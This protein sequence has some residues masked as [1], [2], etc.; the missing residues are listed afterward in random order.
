MAS[1]G[2]YEARRVH[3]LSALFSV[4][5]A[6]LAS[7]SS[8]RFALKV[9]HPPASS[10]IRRFYA[11]EGWL[12][13]IERQRAAAQPGGVVVAI[14][15]SGRCPEGAFVVTAWEE[16][17]FE[18]LVDTVEAKGDHL[19]SFA[20]LL[21]R[22]LADWEQQYGGPHGRLKP[23]N[24]FLAGPG[25]LLEAKAR[26][27]DP[28]YLPGAH[29]EQLRTRDLASV[30]A[31]LV[32]SVR[33]R[34]AGGWPVEDGPEWLALGRAG[35]A[36]L[37]YCNYLL[38]THPAPGTLTIEQ[39][40][41]RLA[42]I[43]RD[44][45]P[46]RTFALG[47]GAT[48]L[49]VVGGVLGFARFGDPQVMP[50]RLRRLAEATG[51]ERAF[52]TE[53]TPDWARLCRAWATWLGDVQRNGPRWERLENFWAPDDSL[54]KA[55][56]GFQASA[57]K[58]RPQA[59][60]EAAAAETRLGVLADAPPDKVR[61]ELLRG[62]VAESV[63]EAWTQVDQL[64]QELER[65][66]RWADL[67]KLLAVLETRGFVRAAAALRPRLPEAGA[68]PGIAP[69][70]VRTL[71]LFN[72]V[73]QDDAGTLLLATQW[74]EISRL[75]EG[76]DGSGD[77]VQKAMPS[78][79][80]AR[81]ADNPSLGEFAD[82]LAAPLAELRRRRTQFLD[83]VVV[84]ER[85]L[86]ECPLQ[87]ETRAV[88]EEDL[89][90]WEQELALYSVVKAADD[91][92]VAP[93]L[94][95]IV[96][97]LGR[98]AGDL[99][100]EA[101]A[102]DAGTVT[103]GRGDFDRAYSPLT[104]QLRNLR[105]RA[106]VRR[107]LAEV[108]AE[109]RHLVA[110]LQGLERQLEAT[111]ALL[112]PGV[113]LERMAGPVGK[114]E[115]VRQRWAAWQQ[116][117]LKGL[118]VAVLEKDRARFR[119][120]R[121]REQLIREVLVGLEGAEGLGG[122]VLPALDGVGADAAAALRRLEASRREDTARAAVA[123]V[124]WRGP[125]PA[126]GWPASLP[127]VRPVLEAHARW[128]S[129]LPSFGGELDRLA[130]L[131]GEG[132]GWDE[133]VGDLIAQ[134]SRREGLGLLTGPV[135]ERLADARRL[136]GLV[137][138]EDRAELVAAGQGGGLAQK[139]TVWRRLGSLAG[140]P[141]GAEDLDRDGALVSAVREL[142]A[143]E[144]KPGARRESLLGELAR[145]T[146]VR[147]NRAARTASRGGEAAMTAVFERMDRVG[148][149]Q[150]D[151]EE[152]LAYNFLLWQLKRQ[153]P[154]EHDVG[155]LGRRRDAFA[156][157]VRALP[158]GAR[159]EI[160]QFLQQLRA[161]D[162]AED[163]KRK[164]SAS[165]G[166][167]PGWTEESADGGKTVIASWIGPEGRRATLPYL[168]V[169]PVDDT[170]PFYLAQRELAVGEFLDLI[171]GRPEEGRLVLQALPPWALSEDSLSKPWNKP[172]AWRPRADFRGIEL[173][174]TWIYLPDA[175]V[176][177]LLESAELR[178][179]TP[180][181]GRAVSEVPTPRSPLQQVP[182]DAARACVEKLFGARLPTPK[183]WRSL[184]M[185]YP[186]GAAG[187]VLR[188]RSFQELWRFLETQ[189]EGGQGVRWRPGEGVF[190]PMVASPD[191]PR[192][193]LTDDGQAGPGAKDGPL[194]PAP[195]D[196]GPVIGGFVNL[197]G[198]VWVYL[199]DEGAKQFYVAGGSVLSPPGVDPTAP[200][201]V[202]VAGLIGARRV[203]EGFSDVGIRPAFDAPPGIRER[204]RLLLLVKEQPYLAF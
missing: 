128:V 119:Q 198:N 69:D 44:A 54:R 73:S 151:L 101:P 133:G 18:P 140:W 175:Q 99:E 98:S 23:S 91:P 127:K 167:L 12:L 138:S 113:W 24:V 203:T 15:A 83:P 43:P 183:E 194:W 121:R 168:L 109:A 39:A 6:V 28:W 149:G 37:A 122:L 100:P 176:K 196:Q 195:V 95:A 77:R 110:S 72:A 111:L 157:A 88:S 55:L 164:P 29:P 86:K 14:L 32:Q 22:T 56:I 97:R 96:A 93:E 84:R 11:V 160:A 60:V 129:E 202:E 68:A 165:P 204:F 82:S 92:R 201:K 136:A 193:R 81:L 7:D 31:M 2:G 192:R 158:S 36:W 107:D 104:D 172:M 191:G 63:T 53:V 58:L 8:G 147:W 45:R 163:P 112:K 177:G 125:Q 61:R 74:G 94:D 173:N 190:L 184:V 141:G 118:T 154:G 124:G 89:L 27:G 132:Y 117:E 150:G 3:A 1:Y 126:Q 30:G 9:F 114:I 134:L 47:T 20:S 144:L 188:G 80:L 65:W 187:G 102:A 19:R 16:H 90:R 131:L 162:L 49:L 4:H 41:R 179:A 33:R 85:F 103:L 146:R 130:A 21:L 40:R 120:L 57:D 108:G 152:P 5:E 161:V 38:D 181:L 105:G 197:I 106:I 182:P 17:L 155:P 186:T 78:L 35:P 189:N 26:L 169:E 159:P 34:Q 171:A 66:P 156:D 116:A 178:A 87:A 50:R 148:I 62:T 137:A 170:P 76:M 25:P 52:R 199:Y 153:L 51:N 145:E 135:V 166:R 13:A 67:R 123:A 143:R 10:D 46:G 71:K 115:V 139:L 200:F 42:G 174:P 59:L 75:V 64:S 70:V 180:A 142:L 48:A 185:L 79:I